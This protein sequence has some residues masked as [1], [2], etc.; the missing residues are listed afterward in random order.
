[1]HFLLGDYLA[2]AIDDLSIYNTREEAD[3]FVGVH[4]GLTEDEMM[5]PLIIIEKQ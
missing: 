4:A 2:I 1:M 5:I 3:F